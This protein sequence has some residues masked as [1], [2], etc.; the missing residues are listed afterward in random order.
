[1]AQEASRYFDNLIDF[2]KNNFADAQVTLRDESDARALLNM[3]CRYGKH[4]V[5][6]RE[7]LTGTSRR[8]SYY[9]LLGEEVVYGFDNASDITALR[10][11]YG[12]DAKRHIGELIS[13][14]HTEGK[15]DISLTEEYTCQKL[16]KWIRT[17][18]SD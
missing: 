2:V 11:K 1:M 15:R 3:E 10:M 8:Y 4:R 5:V 18:I 9:L 13:H 6:I 17:N 7:I 16:V 12:R 14:C